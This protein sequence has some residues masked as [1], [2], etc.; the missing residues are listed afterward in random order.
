MSTKRMRFAHLNIKSLPAK[1][2]LLRELILKEQY[3]TS[4][5]GLTETWLSSNIG[6][7]L[8][9]IT[10]YTFIRRS[11]RERG[12]GRVGGTDWAIGCVYRAPSLNIPNFLDELETAVGNSVATV[13]DILFMGDMNIDLIN[14]NSR[15]N[16]LFTS[17]LETVGLNQ[18]V[19]EPTRITVNSQTLID[20][21]CTFDLKKDITPMTHTFRNYRN[22]DIGALKSELKSIP[23]QNLCD[24]RDIDNKID[25]FNSA[26]LQLQNR[27]IP[28]AVER[29]KNLTNLGKL[30]TFC[31]L[32][33]YRTRHTDFEHYKRIKNLT[34]STIRLE[35]N[36]I[37][38]RGSFKTQTMHL[39]SIKS[40]SVGF[41]GIEINFLN[42][43]CP[44]LLPFI[45]YII[46]YC[47]RL[48][49]FPKEWKLS[50]IKPIPKNREPQTF[51]GLR[52]ISILSAPSKILEQ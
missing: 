47:L 34:R 35:K 37:W 52:P 49:V 3:D 43:C 29:L 23:W 26:M 24:A 22:L 41:D 7:D 39:T 18:I 19:T 8:L 32:F 45:T 16:A 25:F 12:G 5:F 51:K 13:D 21:I 46:N 4:I 27:H 42:L 44:F 20:V 40:N 1:V 15:G 33:L 2:I 6:S 38:N 30:I 50:K 28:I 11:R 48:A 10:G 36:H 9:D 31:S 14:E 17:L